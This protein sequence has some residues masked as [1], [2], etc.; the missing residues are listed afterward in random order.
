MACPTSFP[1][2]SF[3][4]IHGVGIVHHIGIE[5]TFCEVN[6]LLRPGGIAVF[7]EPM[8]NSRT[9]EACKGWLHARL[10]KRLDLSDVT[11]HETVLKW[12]ELMRYSSQFQQFKLHPLNL[13]W[14]VRK[15]FPRP[16]WG[17]LPWLDYWILRTAPFLRHFAGEVLIY[18]QTKD[19]RGS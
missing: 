8:G 1:D 16:C 9:L 13:L 17:P 12:S 11:E 6:R 10:R 2:R 14:R 3:D 5:S 4:I 7:H 18:V 15:L 19:V